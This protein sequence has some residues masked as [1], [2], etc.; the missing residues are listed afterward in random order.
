MTSVIWFYPR[1]ESESSDVKEHAKV[2]VSSPAIAGGNPLMLENN[3]I[4]IDIWQ[5]DCPQFLTSS[6]F[7]SVSYAILC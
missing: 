7:I 4:D 2:A 6:Y 3:S 5:E 1:Q